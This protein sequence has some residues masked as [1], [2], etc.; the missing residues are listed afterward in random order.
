[1]RL[2]LAVFLALLAVPLGAHDTG[3]PEETLK[4]VFPDATGFTARKKTLTADQVRQIERA[5]GSPLQRNDNP[6]GFFVALGKSSDGTGVLGTVVLV[7][8][9]GPKGMIDLA[10]GLKRDGS[11]HRVVV[12][13]NADD[14]GLSASSFLDQLKGK[15]S[16]SPLALGKDVRYEGNAKAAEAVLGAVRRGMLLLAAAGAK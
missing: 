16:Q 4:K 3:F 11:V 6:V 5:S 14:P 8:A 2:Y 9:K 13:E 10:V 15:T 7:D 1:M 12:A